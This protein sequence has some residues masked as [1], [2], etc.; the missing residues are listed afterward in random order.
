M[1]ALRFAF[2]TNNE[3]LS[4]CNS[5]VRQSP[6]AVNKEKG[7]MPTF[8]AHFSND[9][10]KPPSPKTSPNSKNG[11]SLFNHFCQPIFLINE[12]KLIHAAI[13]S[14]YFRLKYIQ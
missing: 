1:V 5:I 8:H 6:S 14:R 4:K 7:P 11:M 2:G 12:V 13:I 3:E 10:I 9:A